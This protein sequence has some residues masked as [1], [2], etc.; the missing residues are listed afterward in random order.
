M[1]QLRWR[2]WHITDLPAQAKQS[3]CVGST[4]LS[5]PMGSAR[6]IQHEEIIAPAPDVRAPIFRTSV[7][8]SRAARANPDSRPRF[9]WMKI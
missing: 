2:L 7:R 5:A 8:S 6:K 4:D 1:K 9:V 3:P